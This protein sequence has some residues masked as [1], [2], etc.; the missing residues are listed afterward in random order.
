MTAS[1]AMMQEVLHDTGIYLDQA[2][3]AIKQ[4]QISS[5]ADSNGMLAVILRTSGYCHDT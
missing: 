3:N 4:T 2:G 5:L 1:V